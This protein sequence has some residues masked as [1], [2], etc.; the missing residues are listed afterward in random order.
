MPTKVVLVGEVEEGVSKAIESR[1]IELAYVPIPTRFHD[2]LQQFVSHGL[3]R[4]V[5]SYIEVSREV[6]AR[7]WELEES[8]KPYIIASSYASRLGILASATIPGFLTLASIASYGGRKLIENPHRASALIPFASSIAAKISRLE[9]GKVVMW[10]TPT[11]SLC[12]ELGSKYGYSRWLIIEGINYIVSEASSD[13]CI[14]VGPCTNPY[15]YRALME[16]GVKCIGVKGAKALS[17]LLAEVGEEGM[18]ELEILVEIREEQS[19]IVSKVPSS[20]TPCLEVSLSDEPSSI[21]KKVSKVRREVFK[22]VERSLT[23][24]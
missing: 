12:G 22:L 2:W 17:V 15:A 4:E 14:Y 24:A 20:L 18:N 10:E 1:A 13:L 8:S 6:L 7:D 23:S 19:G 5:G 21:L 16:A 9:L 3:A 11:C